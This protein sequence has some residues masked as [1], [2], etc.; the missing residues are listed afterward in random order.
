VFVVNSSANHEPCEPA[1]EF[2][3]IANAMTNVAMIAASE[4]VLSS[5][6]IGMP[7]TSMTLV[8]RM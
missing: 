3:Q 5:K 6:N 4:P 1:R 7:N 8:P 2:W